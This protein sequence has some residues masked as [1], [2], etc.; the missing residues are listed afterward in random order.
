MELS[1]IQRADSG[2]GPGVACCRGRAH[3]RLRAKAREPA[4]GRRKEKGKEGRK[5][6]KE[7]KE[8]KMKIGKSKG[9]EK[10]K[11]KREKKK[12]EGFRKLGEIIGNLGEREKSDFVG[13][14][15]FL[16]C[17]RNF[18]DGG[19]GEVGRPAGPRQAQDSRQGGRQRR[20]GS[21]R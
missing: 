9:K 8:R 3:G 7:E 15:E 18:R 11:K 14:S 2:A 17:W 20:W 12:E 6:R 1:G 4:E 13:F 19:D 10:G 21:T 5:K 16:G